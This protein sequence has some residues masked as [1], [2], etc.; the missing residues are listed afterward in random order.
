MNDHAFCHSLLREVMVEVRA[1]FTPEQIKKAWAWSGDRKHYEF[2]GPNDEYI[3]NLRM[4]DCLTSAKAEGWQ[5][6]LES[7]EPQAQEETNAQ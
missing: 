4:A 5:K 1:K 3:Y 2:H 6:L 7:L